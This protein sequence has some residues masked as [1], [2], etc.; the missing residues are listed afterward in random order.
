MHQNM[1]DAGTAPALSQHPYSESDWEGRVVKNVVL[2]RCRAALA[3][4]IEASAPLW[5]GKGI[6]RPVGSRVGSLC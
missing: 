5:K 6:W 4:C 1:R 2:L 3:F